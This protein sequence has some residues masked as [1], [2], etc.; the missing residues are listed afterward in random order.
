ME[1]V[2][3]IANNKI[4]EQIVYN[5][6]RHELPQNL[7]DLIQDIYEVLLNKPPEFIQGLIDRNEAQY[8]IASMIYTQLRSKTSPYHRKYRNKP[9]YIEETNL[10]L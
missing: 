3:Q 4:V 2:E 10:K 1:P 9:V 5:I 8:F 7:Q 6:N